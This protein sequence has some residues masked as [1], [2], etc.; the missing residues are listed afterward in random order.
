MTGATP[1]FFLANDGK[2]KYA[3]ING[4]LIDLENPKSQEFKQRV[5]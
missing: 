3:V 5:L 1:N 2:L 4:Y